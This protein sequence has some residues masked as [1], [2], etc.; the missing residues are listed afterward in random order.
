MNTH[1]LAWAAGFFDGE[2][3]I[4]VHVGDH[5]QGRPWKRI[6]LYLSISQ[7]DRRVLDRFRDAVGV[8]SVNGPYIHPS[9]AARKNE[10]PRYYFT[11]AKFEHIQAVVAM[12]WQFLSPV[13]REQAL[14][15]LRTVKER[16]GHQKTCKRGHPRTAE[17]T[18][19]SGNVKWCKPC[20]LEQW[21]KKRAHLKLLKEAT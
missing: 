8:G 9:V 5:S 12:L 2:G 10:Q 14:S 19:R 18:Y 11:T 13:K 3:H 7:V 6:D 17:N 20:R 15:A 1:E 4:G 21:A 16:L